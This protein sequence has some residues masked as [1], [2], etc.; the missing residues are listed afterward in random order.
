MQARL[1]GRPV[2]VAD[3]D[4]SGVERGVLPAVPADGPS[5]SRSRPGCSM[6]WSRCRSGSIISRRQFLV[7]S[8]GL[9]AS[10][11]ALNEVFREYAYGETLFRVAKDSG[12]DHRRLSGRRPPHGPVR[13]RRS[14]PPR[15]R[16]LSG[17][18][19]RRRPPVRP[20][21]GRQRPVPELAVRL[22]PLE[23]PRTTPTN[24]AIRGGTGTRS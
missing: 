19:P 14:M 2:G 6:P 20:R 16:R 4:A 9:A 24:T 23:S 3:P 17:G 13:L 5:R 8:A 7:T 15:P 21:P 12:F 18:G 11:V 1:R 22:E 10:F